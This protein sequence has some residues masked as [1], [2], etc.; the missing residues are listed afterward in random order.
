MKVIQGKGMPFYGDAMSHGNLI[1][2][3]E[4]EFPKAEQIK[5]EAR[6]QLKKL[7]PGPKINP[8]P[9]TYEMLEDFHDSMR[10]ESAEGGKKN[11]MNFVKK[12][13]HRHRGHDDEDGMPHG[14]QRVEC[15][16]Q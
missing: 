9:Q 10:N 16:T 14:G 11:F 6:E 8:P 4:V 1:I 15:G 7:L 2:Q 5:K 3:F 12:L 13:G